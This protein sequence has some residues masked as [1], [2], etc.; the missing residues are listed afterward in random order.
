MF[1]M[2]GRKTDHHYTITALASRCD[3]RPECLAMEDEC[4]SLCD[5][6]PSFC[7]DECGKKSRSWLRG[8]RVC[9][10]YIQWCT[11]KMFMGGGSFSDIG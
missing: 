2:L 11:E 5:P 3:N 9:D 10:G 7:D 1:F 6:R 8:N 4:E